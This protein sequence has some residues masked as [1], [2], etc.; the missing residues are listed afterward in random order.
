MIFLLLNTVSVFNFLY[1]FQKNG[2]GR[3]NNV[4]FVPMQALY[5]LVF[6]IS[7]YPSWLAVHI[8]KII[9]LFLWIQSVLLVLKRYDLEF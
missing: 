6:C 4:T 9:A 7:Q 3:V 2:H 1:V 5:I 8:L